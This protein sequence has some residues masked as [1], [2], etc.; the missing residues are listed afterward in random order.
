MTLDIIA[1]YIND[2]YKDIA[3]Q[4]TIIMY[5]MQNYLAGQLYNRIDVLSKKY[6]KFAKISVV[7]KGSI[8][9]LIG[10]QKNIIGIICWN[11]PTYKYDVLQLYGRMFRI[12][13][14]NPYYFFITLDKYMW[15]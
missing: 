6:P 8:K 9:D 13:E 3:H 10:W 2:N 5:G 4:S 1:K 14:K 12:S 7:A 11:M 15:N